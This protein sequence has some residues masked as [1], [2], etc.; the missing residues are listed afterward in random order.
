MSASVHRAQVLVA[1]A[2][3]VLATLVTAASALA[4]VSP[5]PWPQ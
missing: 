3:S 1:L 2:V 4:G 5:G